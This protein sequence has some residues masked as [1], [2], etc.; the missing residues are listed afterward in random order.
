MRFESKLAVVCKVPPS[1]PT[2]PVAPPILAAE[3]TETVP[4]LTKKSW[5]PVLV[6][7][8][9]TVPVPLKRATSKLV[10]EPLRVLSP[11]LSKLTAS[12]VP[13][14]PSSEKFPLAEV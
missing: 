7:V 12:L 9:V 2:L 13:A 5:R 4:A 8:R 11:E 1:R 10:I 6:P 3:D 14:P